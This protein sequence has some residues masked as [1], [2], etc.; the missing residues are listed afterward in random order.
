M[1]EDEEKEG[2]EEEEGG[3]GG[4]GEKEEEDNDNDDEKEEGR[5]VF[6]LKSYRMV[7]LSCRLA[8]FL[9]LFCYVYP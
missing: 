2:E 8:E 6:S 9:H 3:G 7:C 4:R 1:R 5:N